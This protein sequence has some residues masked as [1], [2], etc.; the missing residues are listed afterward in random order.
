[1]LASSFSTQF[2]GEQLWL[3]VIGPPSC[4]KTTLMEGLATARKWYLSKDTIR[5][6]HS[7][8]KREDNADV[9]LAD[10]VKGMTLGTKDGDT[11][12]KAPNLKQILAE[13]RALYDRVS[14]T[15]YR[16]D[17]NREYQGHRMTWHLAGTNALRE[18]DDSELGVRF[19]DVVVMDKIDDEFEYEVC[20]RAV[21]QE[22]IN[23]RHLSDGKPET[24]YPEDLA[25]AM[26]LSGGYLDFL[27]TNA[28]ELARSLELSDES[29]VNRCIQLGIFTAFM[30]ARSGANSEEATREFGPRL[31]T[32]LGRL[33]TGLAC[34]FNKPR[35][36]DEV[37]HKTWQV[38]MHT[39]RGPTL[40]L[41]KV[42]HK[43]PQGIEVRGLAALMRA[44]DDKL[45]A[46]LRFLRAIGVVE[47]DV[48]FKRWR[49]TPKLSKLYEAVNAQRS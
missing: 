12:L 29:V 19:L 8:W 36:D 3:K 1:M 42:L 5:G 6:F 45:R 32:Q 14:R 28:V 13:A 7:G 48:N 22:M 18:I 27:R 43:I 44:N 25:N 47:T 49:I 41:V 2:V 4:G 24:Q 10:M 40:E 20:W 31:T 16:N 23:M 15:N 26:A 33:A 21:N 17:T 35:V 34:V 39:S 11:L 46:Q 30:R 38:A 37:M 9:S